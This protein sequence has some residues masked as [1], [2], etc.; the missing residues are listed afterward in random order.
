MKVSFKAFLEWLDFTGTAYELADILSDLGFPNDGV[1][2]LG[3]GLDQVVIAKVLK[4][5]KHPQADRLNLL[6]VST[7]SENLPI[8]CGAQNMKVGDWV[9]LAPVG[10]RVPGKDGQGLSIKEAKI[11]GMLSRGMCCS[12]QELRL[13]EE[14]DGIMILPSLANSQKPETEFLGKKVGDYY[15][16][17][18]WILEVDITPNRGDCLGLRGLAREVAAKLSLKLKPLPSLKWKFPAAGVNP[19]IESFLDCSGFAACLVQGVNL[20]ESPSEWKRFLAR[21]GARSISNL[22][23]ITNKVMFELGHPLHFFDAEKVDPATIQVRRAKAGESLEL[24]SGE[25]IKLD[26]EDLVIADASGPLSL[27]GVM[28]GAHTG[29][30]ESTKNILIEVACFNPARIRETAKR[31]HLH[32]EA[33]FRFARHL[34][35]YRLDDTVERALFLLKEASGFD[36]AAGTKVVDRQLSLKTLLFDRERVEAKLGKIN[37]TNDEIFEMLRRLDYSFDPRGSKASVTIPWYRTDAECLEDIMEDI[38]R[39]IGYENLEKKTLI[40]EESKATLFD[41]QPMMEIQ[42]DLLSKFRGVGFEEAIHMSF[43]DPKVAA[44]FLWHENEAVQLLNPIHA[45]KSCLRQSLIPQLLATARLNAFHHEEG[46][47]LVEVGPVFR[48]S[49]DADYRESPVSETWKVA[50]VWLH[51]P[52]DD[53][54]LFALKN[55]PF[56]Q[57]KGAVESL[58]K[59]FRPTVSR[60]EWKSSDLSKAFH[61]K[62]MIEFRNGYAGELHPLAIRAFDLPGRCFAGEWTLSVKERRMKYQNPKEFPP[63]DLDLSLVVQDSIRLEEIMKV[64]EA[65]SSPLIE[66]I[67]CYDCFKADSLGAEK[68]SLTFAMRYRAPDRTLTMDEARKIHEDLLAKAQSAFPAGAIALR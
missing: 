56:F 34:T 35:P 8:V 63:I 52:L 4:K 28:G 66:W 33:A 45:D 60:L 42:N 30:S 29:V 40:A 18:D 3:E 24:L 19:Q 17:E 43:A 13:G 21:M 32:T 65:A 67:R 23:D 20:R 11:R 49:G 61:P 44:Q 2:H 54:K 10:S 68:K 62:R 46:I 59:A 57:F 9:A 36:Q 25:T 16:Y 1:T 6:E 26:V 39:L 27:A 53:K 47:R 22:V 37:K 51:R 50:C 64:F 48:K 58:W 41:I 7:G 12:E 15:D 5:E 14:S 31:H 55:D 38:A